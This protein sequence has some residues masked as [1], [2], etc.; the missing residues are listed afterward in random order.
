MRIQIEDWADKNL[1]YNAIELMTEAV[2]CYKVGASRAAFLLSY[3][4][5]KTTIRERVLG[6]VK[7]DTIDDKC[8]EEQIIN[9][10]DN[11]NKWEEKLNAIV[12]ASKQ[13]GKGEGAVFRFTNYERIKNRYE[14]WK[15]VRNSCAHAKGEHITSCTVEQ[16]WNYMQDDISEFYVLGGRVYLFDR[17]MYS[18]KYFITVGEEKLRY[19]L[20]DI[21]LVYKRNT[22][23]CF[24]KLYEKNKTCLM[25][26]KSNI[27]FWTTVIDTDNELIREAF[28]DFL[29]QHI[30][31]FIEWYE[32]FPKIFVFMVSRHKTFI[33]EWLMPYLE[34]GYYIEENTF[35]KLLVEVLGV[36]SNLVNLDKITNNYNRFR[37]I[38]KIELQQMELAV[39]HKNK[40][41]KKFLYNAGKEYF[42]NDAN[43]HWS[44]YAHDSNMC[45]MF[46]EKCFEYVEWDIDV[47]EKINLSYRELEESDNMRGNPDSKNNASIRRNSYDRIIAKYNNEIVQIIE[48]NNKD[49]NEYKFVKCSLQKQNLV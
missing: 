17:L 45:D 14:Y 37:M 39:L 15:N 23:Q 29:Y 9:P 41:F 42:F 34:N 44:Y 40:V 6:A 48:D 5:F 20:K 21:A 16:F 3:L 43:S 30:D 36:D 46:P 13:D 27:G 28:V 47:V 7:P 32:N 1:T 10:L 8:W 35:W 31:S 18:Y 19:I 49:L 25:L 11:D 22:I 4:A 24:E 33:Q 12:A 26:N 38:E 2:M